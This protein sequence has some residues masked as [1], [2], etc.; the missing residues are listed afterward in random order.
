MKMRHLILLFLAFMILPQTAFGFGG[1]ELLLGTWK[2]SY[3]DESNPGK[4][5]PFT[6]EIWRD[7][8]GN[9]LCSDGAAENLFSPDTNRIVETGDGAM[10]VA[11]WTRK[12]PTW[13][14]EYRLQVLASSP[15]AMT[16]Y[17]STNQGKKVFRQ[18]AYELRRSSPRISPAPR[19]SPARADPDAWYVN[20]GGQFRMRIPFG[21]TVIDS[22]RKAGTD[23]LGRSDDVSVMLVC[24]RDG[25]DVEGLSVETALALFRESFEKSLDRPAISRKDFHGMPALRAVSFDPEKEMT[26]WT[27]LAIFRDRAY[28]FV[29]AKSGRDFSAT[30]P[31]VAVFAWASLEWMIGERSFIESR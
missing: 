11:P 6:W 1:E 26:T 16:G 20:P 31:E 10:I 25:V 7:A 29:T 12:D 15:D 14:G 17:E 5:I 8:R 3:W 30:E 18:Y 27:T 13:H 9:L 4:R 2:G 22:D 23:I 24:D 28:Q 19:Q 21:W